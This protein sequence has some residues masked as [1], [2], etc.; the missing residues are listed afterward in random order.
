MNR[1]KLL[2]K[3]TM[4][5]LAIIVIGACTTSGT[6]VRNDDPPSPEMGYLLAR[7]SKPSNDFLVRFFLSSSAGLYPSFDFKYTSEPRI[8]LIKMEPGRYT[9]DRVFFKRGTAAATVNL[10]DHPR[11]SEP[12]IV[13][14]GEITYIGAWKAY[15]SE[16]GVG[17][18]KVKNFATTDFEKLENRYSSFSDLQ[19][20]VY[21][22]GPENVDAAALDPGEVM[23][24]GPADFDKRTRVP[25]FF[26]AYATMSLLASLDL[27][28]ELDREIQIEL[29][30]HFFAAFPPAPSDAYSVS[31]FGLGGYLENGGGLHLQL[32]LGPFSE[33]AAQESALY[34]VAVVTN[35]AKEE[36]QDGR[37]VPTR[38][39]AE[40]NGDLLFLLRYE[41]PFV[42]FENGRLVSA[43]TYAEGI[44]MNQLLAQARSGPTGAVNAA[45]TL[46]RD[47]DPSNDLQAAEL[48]EGLHE[49]ESLPA[50]I[51]ATAALNRFMYTVLEGDYATA[52]TQLDQIQQRFGEIDI[53]SWRNA[54]NLEA[55]A[56]L[57]LAQAADTEQW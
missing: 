35:L 40:A 52:A 42:L 26:R 16:Y 8:F 46:I 11:F 47:G 32:V 27:L 45:D 41:Q 5:F 21:L 3:A 1:A 39:A 9:F 57:A 2:V 22:S 6:A 36:T 56:V 7:L 51:R 15:T 50:A 31:D 29:M 49:D 37:F 30:N 28:E 10:T 34:Q 12:L 48:L 18:E 38:R 25:P 33:P 23:F 43:S 54:I 44:D 13:R 55:P 20:N 17:L 14:A 53:E 24:G 4:M 19:R